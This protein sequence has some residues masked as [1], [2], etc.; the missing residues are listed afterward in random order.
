MKA[1]LQTESVHPLIC[2]L[3]CFDYLPAF[4]LQHL[5]QPS[6]IGTVHTTLSMS[7]PDESTGAI[8]AMLREKTTTG[9]MPFFDQLIWGTKLA[10]DPPLSTLNTRLRI[11][12]D[13]G[14]EQIVWAYHITCTSPNQH[15]AIYEDKHLVFYKEGHPEELLHSDL[16]SLTLDSPFHRLIN[17]KFHQTSAY[18]RA[19]FILQGVTQ[20]ISC[21]LGQSF[22][23]TL[24][25]VVEV[26]S[27]CKVSCI[28]L[29]Y[30]GIITRYYFLGHYNIEHC[31][32][33]V[34]IPPERSTSM[35]P[36]CFFIFI[37]PS[38]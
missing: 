4:S 14:D 22:L 25:Q 1:V 8:R 20:E 6:T 31:L 29:D 34:K 13:P 7:A 35:P 24:R 15:H 21:G 19:C 18:A 11:G 12:I 30:E 16:K 9:A 36:D 38:I 2:G 26:I 10:V 28:Y 5:L 3:G 23:Q 17:Y 32:K 33:S 27:P 37:K